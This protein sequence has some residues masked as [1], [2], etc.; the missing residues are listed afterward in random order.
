MERLWSQAKTTPVP[1]VVRLSSSISLRPPVLRPAQMRPTQK[2]YYFYS[3]AFVL[4]RAVTVVLCASSIHEESKGIKKLLYSVPA[5][6]YSEE[7]LRDQETG[8]TLT[9]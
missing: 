6:C 3:F 5:R 9:H 8:Q 1:C 2:L 4:I 7:V